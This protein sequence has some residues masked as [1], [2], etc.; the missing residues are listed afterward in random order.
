MALNFSS[1]DELAATGGIQPAQTWPSAQP[2]QIRAVA[3]V[4]ASTRTALTLTAIEARFKGCG[5][6]KKSLSRILDTLEAL[7]PAQREGEGWRSEALT[8][9]MASQP[10]I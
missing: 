2:D 10:T 1:E 4:L 8:D 5:P 6:W 3:Q 7:G 9:T